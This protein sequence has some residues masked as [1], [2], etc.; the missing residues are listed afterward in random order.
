MRVALIFDVDDDEPVDLTA[1][2]IEFDRLASDELGQPIDSDIVE[3][4]A[5]IEDLRVAAHAGGELY[6]AIGD[7]CD[8]LSAVQRQTLEQFEPDVEDD[9]DEPDVEDDDDDEIIDGQ[10]ASYWARV[11]EESGL[12]EV[13]QRSEQVVASGL[14]FEDALAERDRLDAEPNSASSTTTEVTDDP[15]R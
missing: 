10:V 2:S 7:P 6:A 4:D 14:T 8:V 1:L 13:V 12:Y 9:D 3:L 15:D 5:S 11:D